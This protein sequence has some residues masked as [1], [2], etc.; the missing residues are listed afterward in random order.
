[1]KV[2][3]KCGYEFDNEGKEWMTMCKKCYAQKMAQKE[4]ATKVSK[5]YFRMGE[6]TEINEDILR[7]FLTENSKGTIFEGALVDIE[8]SPDR[9]LLLLSFDVE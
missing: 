4:E 9:E 1:M 6:F 2:K 3:C 8:K 5:I 7:F